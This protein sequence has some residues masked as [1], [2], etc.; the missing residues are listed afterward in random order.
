MSRSYR[1]PNKRIIPRASNGRFRRATLADV[2][3]AVCEK[4]GAIYSPDFSQAKVGRFIDPEK[5]NE[6]KRLCPDCR[7]YGAD[8][9]TGLV[10]S[11]NNDAAG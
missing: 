2:G 11:H 6:I 3:L 1:A 4:C 10:V 5:L 9:T 8:E 7:G